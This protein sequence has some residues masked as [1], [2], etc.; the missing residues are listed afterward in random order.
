MGGDVGQYNETIVVNGGNSYRGIRGCSY[1]STSFYMRAGTWSGGDPSVV[2][3]DVG[4]HVAE[5]PEPSSMGIM[6]LGGL[7][8]PR[9]RK[10]V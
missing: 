2:F 4:F 3:S 1:L 7:A 5:V 10:A 9:R 8:L 6:A